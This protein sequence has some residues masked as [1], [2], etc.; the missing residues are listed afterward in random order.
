MLRMVTQTLVVIGFMGLLLF[1]AAGTI[2]WPQGWVFLAIFNTCT[3]IFGMW[4]RRFDS[5]LVLERM[6]SPMGIDQTPRDR[7]VMG[8]I[9]FILMG[10]LVFTALDAQRFGW[11]GTPI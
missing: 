10:W 11:S 2:A 4:L 9:A 3:V 5:D 6:K 1:P 7:L 8:V